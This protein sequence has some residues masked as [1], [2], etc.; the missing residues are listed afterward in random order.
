[1]CCEHRDDPLFAAT[2]LVGAIAL[3]KSYPTLGDWA[4]W[5]ALLASYSELLPRAS[6]S[7]SLCALGA[8]PR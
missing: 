2:M 4:L 7:I 6:L 3:L 1:M 8:S 5:H